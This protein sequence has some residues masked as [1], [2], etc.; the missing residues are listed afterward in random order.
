[1]SPIVD[2]DLGSVDVGLGQR[3]WMIDPLKWEPETRSQKSRHIDSILFSWP[4]LELFILSREAFPSSTSLTSFIYFVREDLGSLSILRILVLI[5]T[6]KRPKVVILSG[7]PWVYPLMSHGL[8]P[9]DQSLGPR[10]LRSPSKHQLPRLPGP[11]STDS[12]RRRVGFGLLV[13][14]W[15]VNLD[16]HKSNT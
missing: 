7:S 2:P 11:P 13:R 9:W 4:T 16:F 6:L 3:R 8:G 10:I 12:N 14:N 15:C 1:M 5:P